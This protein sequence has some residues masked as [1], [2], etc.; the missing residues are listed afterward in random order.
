MAW[1]ILYLSIYRDIFN[2]RLE[3]FQTE[4]DDQEHDY[5]ENHHTAADDETDPKI[6]AHGFRWRT[7]DRYRYRRHCDHWYR[8]KSVR[9]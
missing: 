2:F 9:K 6:L 8:G 7:R 3:K 5:D 1:L 4:F